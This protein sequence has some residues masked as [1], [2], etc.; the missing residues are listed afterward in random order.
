MNRRQALFKC[1][2]KLVGVF[3]SFYIGQFNDRGD[4]SNEAGILFK[5]S[6]RETTGMIGFSS[7]QAAPISSSTQ[8]D[9]TEFG[10]NSATTTSAADNSLRSLGSHFSAALKSSVVNT[11][12]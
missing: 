7:A 1:I 8:L 11:W 6:R 12:A 10:V 4:P 3:S 2:H 5:T 9:S